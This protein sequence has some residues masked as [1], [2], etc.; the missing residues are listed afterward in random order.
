MDTSLYI[1][2]IQLSYGWVTRNLPCIYNKESNVLL[3]RL[4]VR[5]DAVE[6]I[7]RDYSANSGWETFLA[8]EDPRQ[9][10]L[11]GLLR[12]RQVS[13][14]SD[15]ERQ[16]ELR[17]RC[18]CEASCNACGYI[19]ACCCA[20]RSL[21]QRNMASA[22][23]GLPNVKFCSAVLPSQKPRQDVLVGLLRLRQV[24]GRSDKERQP[25]LRGR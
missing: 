9:D 12:L 19:P 23:V 14:R 22:V 17:G 6:L 25:E 16:P 1:Q 5:P 13:G 4:Q 2:G 18:G 21:L 3:Q 10:V 11:V 20:L 8:Y 24:S 7:R 15:K